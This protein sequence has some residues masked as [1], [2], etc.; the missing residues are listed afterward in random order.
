MW[1]REGSALACLLGAWACGDASRRDAGD[2]G[3]VGAG[4]AAQLVPAGVKWEEEET[5][6][7]VDCPATTDAPAP[8]FGFFPNRIWDA[9]KHAHHH[10]P[11]PPLTHTLL[12]LLQELVACRASGKASRLVAVAPRA[13]LPL[14]ILVTKL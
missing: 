8:R 12:L 3:W 1:A 4:D 11:C 2:E 5:R 14:G 10:P 9:L 13:Q 7:E 6:R